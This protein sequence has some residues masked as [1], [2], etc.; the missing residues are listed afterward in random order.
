MTDT[1]YPASLSSH[2]PQTVSETLRVL[3][4]HVL[5]KARS[6]PGRALQTLV[7]WQQRADSRTWLAAMEER[8]RRD[9][10]LTPAAIRAETQ[11][12]FWTA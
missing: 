3:S 5:K 12:P 6:L 8:L 2:G 4:R 7:V 1:T 9:A 11:K 10:G